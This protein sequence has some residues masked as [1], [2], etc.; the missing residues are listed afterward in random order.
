MFRQIVEALRQ[1]APHMTVDDF[2]QSLA[3]TEPPSAIFQ[4]IKMWVKSQFGLSE[5]PTLAALAN[6]GTK[7]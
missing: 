2:R 5:A 6:S 3:A 1:G 4:A 7:T